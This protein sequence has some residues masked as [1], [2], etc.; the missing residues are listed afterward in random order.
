MAKENSFDIVSEISLQE[1][2]NALNQARQEAATRYDLKTAAC[3]IEFDKESK[4]TLEAANDF[5]L[6]S[7]V[8]IVQ[9]KLIRRGIDIKALHLGKVEPA[10]G[11]RARQAGQFIKGISTEIGRDINKLLKQTKLKINIQIQG[12]Q[13]RVTGKSKDDLQAAMRAVKERDFG[14]PIQFVNYR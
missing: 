10:S 13:V 4:L 9:S 5:S 8:D 2:D 6:K 11:G 1:I 3:V 14:I 12:D 7:L